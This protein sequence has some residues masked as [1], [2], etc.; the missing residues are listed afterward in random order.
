MSD[1]VD[2]YARTRTRMIAVVQAHPEAVDRRV[3]ACPEWTVH[4]LVAHVVALPAAIGRGDLPGDDLAGWLAGLVEAR[5]DQG[6][7]DLCVEWEGLDDAIAGVLAGG[8]VLF[9]DL[10]VHEHDLRGAV[11]EPDHDAL[12]VD[13]VVPAALGL[14]V[15]PVREHGLGAIEVVDGD[16]RWASHDAEPGWTLTTTAWEAVRAL[17]SRRTVD[18]LRA[19]PHTG[20]PEPYLSLLDAHLPLPTASLGEG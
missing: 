4:D 18:E 12:E 16:R 20:D 9:A 14:L 10:A 19:L 3:P 17:N 15:G 2:A 1:V 13:L 6:V 11:G 7:D 8:P 5:A